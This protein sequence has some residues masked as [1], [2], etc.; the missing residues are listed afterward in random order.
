MKKKKKSRKCLWNK[1]CMK[2]ADMDHESSLEAKHQEVSG[3][4]TTP[5]HLALVF[6]SLEKSGEKEN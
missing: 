2:T 1:T 3:T 5:Q 6:L 4:F